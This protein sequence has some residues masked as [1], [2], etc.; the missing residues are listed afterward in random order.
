ME[1][2]WWALETGFGL[3]LGGGLA[4]LCLLLLIVGVVWF[5]EIGN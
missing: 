1:W 5:K 2:F 3:V 4:L